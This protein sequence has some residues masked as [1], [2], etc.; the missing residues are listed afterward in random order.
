M[1]LTDDQLRALANIAV[2]RDGEIVQ[3]MLESM[4]Q[5]SDATCRTAEGPE[6]HRAQGRSQQIFALLK[7]LDDAKKRMRLTH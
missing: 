6:L 2:S 5:M 3:R 4:L 1:T 7:A